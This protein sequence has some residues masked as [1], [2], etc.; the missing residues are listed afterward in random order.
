MANRSHLAA[1]SQRLTWSSRFD[2]IPRAV[3]R[4]AKLRRAPRVLDR[5]ERQPLDISSHALNDYVLVGVQFKY[6]AQPPMDSKA[7]VSLLRVALPGR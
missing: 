1:E 6:S 5:D 2:E 3:E 4:I 7:L